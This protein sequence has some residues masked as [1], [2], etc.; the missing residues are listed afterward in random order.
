MLNRGYHAER[1]ETVEQMMQ[2][3][4]V[5]MLVKCNDPVGGEKDLFLRNYPGFESPTK[6]KQ[7]V[8]CLWSCSTTGRWCTPLYSTQL[9]VWVLSML[10][11]RCLFTWIFMKE[12]LGMWQEGMH[13]LE[14]QG[15]VCQ[16][17]IHYRVVFFF[18]PCLVLLMPHTLHPICVPEPTFLLSSSHSQ[19][20]TLS[21]RGKEEVPGLVR[22]VSVLD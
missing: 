7:P 14:A 9:G 6:T 12:T 22:L 16:Y 20:L 21:Q 2:V 11:N 1:Q 4:T 8:K 19:Y 15:C 3:T 18:L 17:L 13:S 5:V 10:T